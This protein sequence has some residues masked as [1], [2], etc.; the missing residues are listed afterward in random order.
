MTNYSDYPITSAAGIEI[1]NKNI[2][3]LLSAKGAVVN[4]SFACKGYYSNKLLKIMGGINKGHPNDND[5]KNA[6]D[7]AKKYI[8][9]DNAIKTVSLEI[10]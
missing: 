4:G 5:I 1:Y 8:I 7:F 3:N 6:S 2:I 9:T 10:Y